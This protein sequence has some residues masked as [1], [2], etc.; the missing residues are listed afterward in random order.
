MIHPPTRPRARSAAAPSPA[1]DAA[2]DGQVRWHRSPRA[3]HA[4][5]RIDAR[6]GQV[7]VILPPRASRR[8]GF[9]LLDANAG[10]VSERLAALTPRLTL[11][12]GTAIPVG[13]APHR[14]R[15][16]RGGRP[17]RPA[18][19][20]QGQILVP[21]P[22]AAVAERVGTLLRAE[23]HR[24]MEALAARHAATLGARVTGLR[25]KDTSSRWGSCAPDGT[26]AF[27][28]RLVMAPGWVLDYVVAHE[29]AHLLELNHSERFWSHVARL[30]PHREAAAAW[31]RANGPAL[32]RVG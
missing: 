29:V 13:G 14:I 27:S 32:L 3:R 25:L 15:L 8:V 20:E 24:R 23:G 21:G 17:G 1:G 11:R 22:A 4:S 9:A 2:P 28:W 10:W 12:P 26:L 16:A 5:L 31:L 19:L 18:W 7:V 30:S 6:A